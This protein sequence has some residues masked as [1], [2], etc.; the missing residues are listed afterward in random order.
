[1]RVAIDAAGRLVIPKALRD[2]L[3]VSGAA[4]LDL[5]V[6]DG[7]V[8]LTVPDAPA[9]VEERDGFAVIALDDPPTEPLTSEQTRAAIERIRR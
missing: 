7:R 5:R 4:E 6:A 1:M 9:R 3:G 8:E 2:E